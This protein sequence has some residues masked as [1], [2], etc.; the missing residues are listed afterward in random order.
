MTD[1]RD[2]VCAA[3][4]VAMTETMLTG[5]SRQTRRP[6]VVHFRHWRPDGLA[7]YR[8]FFLAPVQ[9]S[10]SFDGFACSRA[11]LDAPW[12]WAR[13][14]MTEHAEKLLRMVE[15]KPQD[16]PMSDRVA[17]ALM[18]M[19]PTGR[20]S[21]PNVAAALGSKP[22]SLQR[23][24]E[25]EGTSFGELLNKDRRKLARRYLA[26]ESHSVSAVAELT[27]YSS[28]SAFGRWFSSEFGLAPREW[29]E[30]NMSGGSI[31]AA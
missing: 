7:V 26:N 6:T 9:F 30:V 10:S 15:I 17:R 31:E 12:P 27:G 4:T 25:K 8:R 29:R 1:G 21:L 20:V 3:M 22:R 18:L 16:T 19:L 5:A 2:Q 24:L 11:S 23:M 28:P 14:A 13:K